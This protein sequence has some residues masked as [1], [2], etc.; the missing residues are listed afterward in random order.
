MREEGKKKKTYL[1]DLHTNT[2]ILGAAAR[3]YFSLAW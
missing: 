2:T 3:D 1:K